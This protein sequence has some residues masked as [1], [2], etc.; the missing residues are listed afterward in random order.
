M[1]ARNL[2]QAAFFRE[3]ARRSTM[4]K[5]RDKHPKLKR[6][7]N[8][9]ERLMKGGA[10]VIISKSGRVFRGRLLT[11]FFTPSGARGAIFSSVR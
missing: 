6:R 4:A 5:G 10:F 7:T 3:A 8:R 2:R 9:G 1:P 11:T